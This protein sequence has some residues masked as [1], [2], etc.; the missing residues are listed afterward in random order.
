MTT[1]RGTICNKAETPIEIYPVLF[2]LNFILFKKKET[3][4]TPFNLKTHNKFMLI[5]SWSSTEKFKFKPCEKRPGIR[6]RLRVDEPNCGDDDDDVMTKDW[7]RRP[8][9]EWLAVW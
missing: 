5:T 3:F 8:A 2:F 6:T 1:R 7:R 9:D 4:S